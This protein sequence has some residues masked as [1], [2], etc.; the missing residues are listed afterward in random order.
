MREMT[1]ALNK[2]LPFWFQADHALEQIPEE[3]EVV[4]CKIYSR[5]RLS[6]TGKEIE[7]NLQK[8]K[9]LLSVENHTDFLV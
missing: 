7:N 8:L 1:E 5:Q 4:C 3:P 2:N 6:F 9:F